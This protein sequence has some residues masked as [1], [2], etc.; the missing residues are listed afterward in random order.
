MEI[1]RILVY[2]APTT[3]EEYLA[4]LDWSV[5]QTE[6]PVA[7]KLPGGA[8]VSDGKADE[9]RISAALDQI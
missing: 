1:Y 9:Q 3:K 5:E 2:L 7:I 6:H 4:M 8:M